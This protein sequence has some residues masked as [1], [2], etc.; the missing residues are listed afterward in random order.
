MRRPWQGRGSYRGESLALRDNVRVRMLRL[1]TGA[2]YTEQMISDVC[3]G[4]RKRRT[5]ELR[6]LCWRDSTRSV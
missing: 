2:A 6:I 4:V 3:A 1:L 5:T